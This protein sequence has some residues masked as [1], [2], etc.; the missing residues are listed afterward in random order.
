MGKGD[1]DCRQTA[2]RAGP[3][4]ELDGLSLAYGTEAGAVHALD[5]VSLVLHRGSVMGLVGESG[6]GKSSV[7]LALLGLAGANARVTARAARYDGTDLLAAAAKLRGRKVGLVSQDAAAALNP[8]ISIGRQVGETL[9]AHSGHSWKKALRRAETLLAEV[10][11]PNA[12]AVATAYPHQL[13]GGMKQRAV[14]AGALASEPDLLLLDEPTTALD[15]TVEAQI[16]ELLLGLRASRHLSMLFVSH[17]LGVIA[18]VC[19]ELTVLYG[20]RVV[21][22]GPLQDV[23]HRPLHPYTKGLLAA[24]PRIDGDRKA[25]LAPIAGRL[26]DLV[27]VDPGCNFRMRC[28]W[29]VDGCRAPQALD[30]LHG[31]QAVRCHRAWETE[32]Q[33]WI[34]TA[35]RAERAAAPNASRNGQILAAEQLSKR[36]NLPRAG[37]PFAWRGG[38][39]RYLPRG[40]TTALDRVSLE[41]GRG[42]VLGLVGESGSGKSTLGRVLLRLAPADD[43]TIRFDERDVPSH[44]GLAF[45][46]RAQIVFQNSN[47]SMNPRR[48][49]EQI[50]RR[51]LV[52]AGIAERGAVERELDHLLEQVR[53]TPA[54]RR[55]F[56]HQMSGGEKQRVGIARALASRPDFVVCDEAVSALDVSVQA[57]VLNLLADLRDELGVA[58]LFITHDIGVVAH[59]ADRIAVM[60]RGAVV[61]VGPADDIIDRP[62]HP[63]TR[64]LIAAV[65]KL[66]AARPAS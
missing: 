22:Q 57:A 48:T 35:P 59:I 12:A 13:S 36:Y 28:P 27:Q 62:Q 42:E 10:G 14:I 20:G 66:G 52:R 37:L 54:Y 4:L 7:I 19:D 3:L 53:L 23:L 16:I 49:V 11:I 43:G 65:P 39:P 44:P 55:R 2:G 32:G 38:F 41:I 60:R 50:L 1:R 18:K 5:D 64:A 47:S 40:Q 6:S 30:R 8:A 17:N 34:M 51:S 31:G 29:S 9:V 25:R 58:Y 61:E 26:P 33:P 63:Y 15:V 21:E 45:R 46:R 24:L 56:A